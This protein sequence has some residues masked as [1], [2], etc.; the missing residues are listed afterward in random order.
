MKEV[1][2]ILESKGKATCSEISKQLRKDNRTTLEVLE[3][4]EELGQIYAVNGL[5]HLQPGKPV[6]AKSAAPARAKKSKKPRE[7]Q[8]EGGM[9]KRILEILTGASEPMSTRDIADAVGREPRA[10]NYSLGA[11]VNLG[12]A[13]KHVDGKNSSWSLPA[14][15]LLIAPEAAQPEKPAADIIADIPVFTERAT[16]LILPTATSITSE[17]RRTKAKLASLEKLRITVREI[18]R[19]KNLILNLGGEA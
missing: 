17:I 16:D 14:T 8:P 4:M 19:H 7:P 15:A 6:V 11:L 13:V 10:L 18:R 2:A 1:L 5:W 3:R 12:L 9:R